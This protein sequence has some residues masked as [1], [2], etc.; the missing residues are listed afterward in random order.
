MLSAEGYSLCK[1]R[2]RGFRRLR[3]AAYFAHGGSSSQSPLHS[4]SA[5]RRKLRSFPCSSS[6]RR[7]RFAGLRREQRGIGQNA[8]GDGSRWALRA[9]SRPPYPLWP[10]GPSPPDRGSRP[11]TPLRG[12]HTCKSKQNFRR[13]KSEW[14]PQ[15]PPGHW[16]LGLW[17]IGVGAVPLLRLPFPNQR[18]GAVFRRRGGLWPPAGAHSAPLRKNESASEY[19]IGAG[20]LTRPPT[21]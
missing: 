17:K 19:A 12:T 10:F 16:A 21:P 5:W 11:R 8:T 14:H 18:P 4:V 20:V 9:H 1:F 2:R 3:A 15:F 13:A 6:S 7:T